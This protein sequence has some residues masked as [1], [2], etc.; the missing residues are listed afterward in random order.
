MRL[1]CPNCN[2]QYDIASD[3]IPEGGRDVQCSSCS[4]TWFQT[5]KV[6]KPA[7]KSGIAMHKSQPAASERKPLDSSIANILR[8]E[9]AR[10]NAVNAGQAAPAQKPIMPDESETRRRISMMASTENASS[11]AT[12]AAAAT[13]AV[14]EHTLRTVPS[15]DEINEKLRARAQTDNEQYLTQTE[16]QEAVQRRG[17]RRGFSVV[18]LVMA[19]LV[20]PYIFADRIVAQ[21]PQTESAVATYV[22]T[23]NEAR[24]W[25]NAQ[26]QKARDI[27]QG[28]TAP[29]APAGDAPRVETVPPAAPVT[30]TE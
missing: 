21:F 2:A 4:H 24:L 12:V 18:L 17:F 9:A 28:F 20:L 3:A 14:A 13:G 25:L 16:Q 1:V 8:Q 22:E 6:E 19:I 10:E 30:P 5:E 11:R 15:I 27:M 23:V 29:D 26:F 7:Q